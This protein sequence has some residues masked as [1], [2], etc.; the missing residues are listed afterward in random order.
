MKRLA[1]NTA[2]LL[3][4]AAGV[5]ALPGAAQQETMPDIYDAAPR[6]ST[7]VAKK[8]AKPSAVRRASNRTRARHTS[9]HV[10]LAKAQ[11]KST[12]AK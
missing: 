6:S 4:L 3:M 11:P 1:R 5:L 2:L 7:P 9:T 12:M 10:V 8:T